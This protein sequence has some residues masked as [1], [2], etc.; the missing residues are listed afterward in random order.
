MKRKAMMCMMVAKGA[1]PTEYGTTAN[2]DAAVT[3]V[4]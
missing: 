2:D 4:F 3:F 1:L